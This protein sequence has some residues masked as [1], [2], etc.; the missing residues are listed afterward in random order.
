M[1]ATVKVLSVIAAIGGCASVPW[2]LQNTNEKGSTS[3]LEEKQIPETIAS[4]R[5]VKKMEKLVPA[6]QFQKTVKENCQVIDFPDLNNF[7][8]DL[9]TSG[10]FIPVSCEGANKDSS[11]KIPNN[12]KGLFPDYLFVNKS[13]F[14]KGKK[15]ELTTETTILSDGNA[16]TIFEG[17]GLHE[18]VTGKWGEETSVFRGEEVVKVQTINFVQLQAGKIFLFLK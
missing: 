17:T 12:W 6:T 11:S 16:Q 7:L 9:S 14:N 15:F 8:Y 18:V 3:S 1:L 4:P 13:E 10:T 5:E 2:F